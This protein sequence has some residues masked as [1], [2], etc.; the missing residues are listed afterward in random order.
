MRC[1]SSK[2]TIP[3]RP[4]LVPNVALQA[5]RL[6]IRSGRADCKYAL[7]KLRPEGLRNP[8]INFAVFSTPCQPPG[9]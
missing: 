6:R 7:D 8:V 4:C 5:R 2:R 1:P 9:L 3:M